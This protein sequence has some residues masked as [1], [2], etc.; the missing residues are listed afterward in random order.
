[1]KQFSLLI[2]TKQRFLSFWGVVKMC[3]RNKRFRGIECLLF[4]GPYKTAL[5]AALHRQL[6]SAAVDD[7]T[8]DNAAKKVNCAATIE[9]PQQK[10]AAVEEERAIPFLMRLPQQKSRSRRGPQQK[11]NGSFLFYC[12]SRS[13]QQA[14]PLQLKNAATEALLYLPIAQLIRVRL[15][16]YSCPKAHKP[17]EY[18]QKK[19]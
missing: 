4:Q 8:V 2:T 9:E 11:R 14:L 13:L 3:R 17:C 15:I 7:A 5:L 16:Y 10:R 12:G 18:P 1:M 6:R 19:L